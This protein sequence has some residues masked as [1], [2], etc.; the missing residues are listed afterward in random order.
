M[1]R[2]VTLKS[3]PFLGSQREKQMILCND[4]HFRGSSR[5][6][7]APVHCVENWDRHKLSCRMHDQSQDQIK[8]DR[9]MFKIN[10]ASSKDKQAFFACLHQLNELIDDNATDW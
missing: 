6:F 10:R 7:F 8:I 9:L 4:Y 5:A 3:I 2:F 1:S